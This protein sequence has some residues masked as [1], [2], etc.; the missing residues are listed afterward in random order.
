MDGTG[1]CGMEEEVRAFKTFGLVKKTVKKYI[2]IW[3][4]DVFGGATPASKGWKAAG[5]PPT[6]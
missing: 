6:S 2:Y 4:V 3:L 5:I 1:I